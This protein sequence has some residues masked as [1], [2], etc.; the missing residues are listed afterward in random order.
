MRAVL[1]D[2]PGGDRQGG[3][4][5]PRR[6]G[7]SR[8]L[9]SSTFFYDA[10]T[11][12]IGFD[13]DKAK[14]LLAKSSVAERLLL[15]GASA[16][17]QFDDPRHGADLGG[18]ARQI[19][20]KMEIEQIEAT[21]AQDLYNTEQYSLRISGWTNDTPD[22]DE[23]MGVALDYQPQNGLHS[24]YHSD[25]ARDLVLAARKELDQGKRQKLYS[26]AAADRE[27]R[28]PVPLHRRAGTPLRQHAGRHGFQPNSQGKYSFEDVYLS[29]P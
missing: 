25:E 3:L 11:D 2:R 18:L 1:C 14:E 29:Q 8:F 19:G 22:P 28:L 10:N 23:L 20:V 15:Q 13:L 4:F 24:S 5:R 12:P 26:R 17:R 16:E 27:P 6:A 7:A 9:P 21:T